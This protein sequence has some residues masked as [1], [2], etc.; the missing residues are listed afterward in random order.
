MEKRSKDQKPWPTIGYNMDTPLVFTRQ[1]FDTLARALADKLMEPLLGIGSLEKALVEAIGTIHQR[2][3]EA[4]PSTERRLGLAQIT[5]M[6]TVLAEAQIQDILAGVPGIGRKEKSALAAYLQGFVL[7]A[8]QRSRRLEDPKGKKLPGSWTLEDPEDLL[9]LLPLRAIHYRHGQTVGSFG[10]LRLMGVESTGESWKAA[11]A[12]S[13]E[14]AVEQ[15]RRDN[16]ST[17]AQDDPPAPFVLRVILKSSL[18]EQIRARKN[19][20]KELADAAEVTGVAKF[21][22]VKVGDQGALLAW[23]HVDGVPFQGGEELWELPT[24]QLDAP[25]LARWIRRAAQAIGKL[26]TQPKPWVHG[27]L[28]PT[29]LFF[30]KVHDKWR[31]RVTDLGWADLETDYQLHQEGKL[32]LRRLISAQKHHGHWRSLYATPQRRKGAKPTQGDDVYALGLIWY[33]AVMGN[34]ELPPPTGL[35]WVNRAIDRGLTATHGR[36]LS[37]CLALEEARRF[38]SGQE[39]AGELSKLEE[40]GDE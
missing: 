20:L 24:G 10:L 4:I 39:L 2:L 37:R 31:I 13:P 33:Q 27:G 9:G 11:R 6:P 26:H 18:I 5:R 19:A 32:N 22:K 21:C 8:R 30:T 7:I 28:C 12:E 29:S 35:D 3:V 14:S 17:D 25:R 1:L 15:A 40:K 38:V 36:I 23:E 34:W 16:E